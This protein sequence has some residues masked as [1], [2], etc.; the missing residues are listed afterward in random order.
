MTITVS[1]TSDAA[2]KA[3]VLAEA[4]DGRVDNRSEDAGS[5]R[6]WREPPSCCGCPS[7]NSTVWCAS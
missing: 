3:A 1:N 5:A 6:G 4:A 7:R 2:D